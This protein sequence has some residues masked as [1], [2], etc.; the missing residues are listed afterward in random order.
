M[1][2]IYV[3]RRL[4]KHVC[5]DLIECAKEFTDMN[6]TKATLVNNSS[7]VD[8]GYKSLIYILCFDDINRY[9]PVIVCIG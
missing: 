9:S 6:S 8:D 7:E 5:Q 4:L 2:S 1:C 3:C